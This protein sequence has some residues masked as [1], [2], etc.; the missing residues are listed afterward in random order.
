[1]RIVILLLALLASAIVMAESVITS[2]TARSIVRSMEDSLNDRDWRAF[3][4]M[5][6]E[7]GDR[8]LFGSRRAVGPSEV[9]ELIGDEWAETPSDITANLNPAEI[10]VVTTD[11]AIVSIKAEFSGSQPVKD[12]AIL[13]I[14]SGRNGPQ[15]EALRVFNA[16]GT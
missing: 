3:G 15:I 9:E 14:R 12:R 5:F 6:S 11:V 4:S 2:D 10:R 13:V 8:V 7:N 1:M 16:E